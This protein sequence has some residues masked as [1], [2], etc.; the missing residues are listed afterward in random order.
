M[1]VDINLGLKEENTV[2]Y[3][4]EVCDKMLVCSM[5]HTCLVSAAARVMHRAVRLCLDT[6]AVRGAAAIERD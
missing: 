3:S 5:L 2:S 4:S 6:R 1:L